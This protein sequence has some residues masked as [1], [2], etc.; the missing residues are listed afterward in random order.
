MMARTAPAPSP[1]RQT[2]ARLARI[3]GKLATLEED[4][5]EIQAQL[6]RLL[7]SN[8]I[9]HVSDAVRKKYP[10]LFGGNE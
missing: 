7:E 4:A 9:D 1:S 2:S 5:T 6:K 8:G 10:T 3:D